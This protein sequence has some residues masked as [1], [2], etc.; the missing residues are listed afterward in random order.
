MRT[1]KT[2]FGLTLIIFLVLLAGCS[3]SR[4]A[5]VGK[6]L[7]DKESPIFDK[8]FETVALKD[9]NLDKFWDHGDSSDDR[10]PVPLDNHTFSRITTKVK[11]AVVNIYTIRIEERD[12]KFGIS[13]NDLLP[14][15]IPIVSSILDIVP[16]QVP[17]PFKSEGF[18]LGSGFLINREGYILTNAHVI[19]N[20]VNI[21]V[22]LAEGKKE[23]PAKIIGIDRLTDTALIKIEPDFIPTIL[24]FGDSDKLKMGEVVLAMGNPLGFQHS[25][26]SGLISAKERVAPHAGDRYVNFLQTDSAINPGSSGGPL[27]NLY[28]EVVGI[29][30]AIVE[31]AQL[32]GFAI[33]INTVKDVMGMLI[34]GK[35]ERGWFGA[36]ATPLTTEEALELN[37]PDSLGMVIKGLEK[38]SPAE[39]ANLK[40]ND[41]ITG[42]NKEPITNLA[43]FRRKLLALMPGQEIHLTIYRDGKTFEVTSTLAHKKSEEENVTEPAS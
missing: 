30:T 10:E 26:T 31:Q 42:I 16:F 36:H 5:N 11:Q 24:P 8:R 17:I 3:V 18:S 2:K 1:R 40:I 23:Y 39:Q 9:I 13:P 35:T 20:S 15:R 34:I 25:V 4:T 43:I 33:P 22:V 27:I 14:I 19:S 12:T 38:D 37:Y 7:V 28:G 29:N 6:I 32:I 41:I 21:R